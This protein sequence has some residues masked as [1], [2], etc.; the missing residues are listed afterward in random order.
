M[1]SVNKDRILRRIKKCL[2]LSKSSNEHE[3]AAALRQAKALMVKHH[4]EMSE[5]ELPELEVL[6]GLDGKVR[7]ASYTQVE[8]NLIGIVCSFFECSVMFHCKWPVIA[9]QSP[10][11]AIADYAIKVL[12]RQMRSNR[13]DALQNLEETHLGPGWKL[14]RG[15]RSEFNH[16]Y[17]MAWNY[18]VQNKVKEFA[19]QIHPDLKKAQNDALRKHFNLSDSSVVKELETRSIKE[20]E[21][22]RLAVR[23]GVEDGKKAQLNQ[24]MNTEYVEP[25]KLTLMI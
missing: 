14:S 8:I 5:A 23:A 4:I 2:A 16:S 18:A 19:S 12:I 9:G 6:D 13:K 15:K 10:A 11:P 3:A 25:E 1:S 21:L 24:G 20:N 17:G 22:T 7:P